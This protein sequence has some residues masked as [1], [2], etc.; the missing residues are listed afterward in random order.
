M[1]PDIKIFFE[2]DKR[3]ITSEYL[4]D[5]KFWYSTNINNKIDKI[6]I[7][8]ENSY[9]NVKIYCFDGKNYSEKEMLKVIALKAFL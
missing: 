5:T 2:S 1:H 7:C 6:I 3:K 9:F 8:S 4:G